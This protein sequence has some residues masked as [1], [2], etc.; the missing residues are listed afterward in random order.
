MPTA[1]VA[2]TFAKVLLKKNIRL[3]NCLHYTIQVTP[4]TINPLPHHPHGLSESFHCMR[5]HE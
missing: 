1:F 3:L 5:L 4:L 2:Q